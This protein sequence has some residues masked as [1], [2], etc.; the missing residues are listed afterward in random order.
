VHERGGFGP[1]T[2][3]TNSCALKRSYLSGN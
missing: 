2:P 3:M 1:P